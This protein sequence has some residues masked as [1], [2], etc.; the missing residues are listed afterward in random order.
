VRLLSRNRK[1]EDWSPRHQGLSYLQCKFQ[2][3]TAKTVGGDDF[4]AA[5]CPKMGKN[6]LNSIWRPNH[7]SY[8][9]VMIDF[10]AQTVI[11]HLLKKIAS[12]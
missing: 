7:E 11:A 2:T 9:L 1:K 10:F 3:S 8:R 12:L 6:L 5:V 4:Q